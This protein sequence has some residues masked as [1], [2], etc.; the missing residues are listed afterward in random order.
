M[1]LKPVSTL[2]LAFAQI[3]CSIVRTLDMTVS[4][5]FFVGSELLVFVSA[6]A[7]HAVLVVVADAVND[8]CWCFYYPCSHR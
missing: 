3:L 1:C 2:F 4:S 6:I 7:F 8:G 5:R